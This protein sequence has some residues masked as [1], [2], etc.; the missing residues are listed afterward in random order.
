MLKQRQ[1]LSGYKLLL[2]LV[3]GGQ[4][5][6]D[7]AMSENNEFDGHPKRPSE[8]FNNYTKEDFFNRC[9]ALLNENSQGYGFN[10][11]QA[12][13]SKKSQANEFTMNHKKNFESEPD[14]VTYDAEVAKALGLSK[15]DMAKSMNQFRSKSDKT[16]SQV[17]ASITIEEIPSLSTDENSDKDRAAISLM[18]MSLTSGVVNDDN[19]KYYCTEMRKK[20]LVPFEKETLLALLVCKFFSNDGALS[21]RL[22]NYNPRNGQIEFADSVVRAM[23]K[24]DVLVVEAG[25]GTGK[26]FSYLV[27]PLLAGK[28][29]IVSTKTKALQDQL[30]SKDIPNLLDIM[31]LDDVYGISLKGQSNYICRYLLEGTGVSFSEESAVARC[32]KLSEA[33]LKEIRNNLRT[34]NFGEINF[35]VPEKLRHAVCC[36][37]LTCHEMSSHCPYVEN[38]N[39]Y[40]KQANE[41]LS[42]ITKDNDTA[43]ILR[44][45]KKHEGSLPKIDDEQCFAF[46]A[47]QEAK[48]RDIT[49][50]N[51]ALFFAVL[52]SNSDFDSLSS[53]LPWAD[54]L[55]FDEAHTL[56]DVGREFYRQDLSLDMLINLI[57]DIRNIFPNCEDSK[58]LE[59]NLQKLGHI[60]Y[61]LNLTF[62]LMPK[63]RHSVTCFKYLHYEYPSPFQLLGYRLADFRA[64]CALKDDSHFMKLVN[65]ELEKNGETLYGSNTLEADTISKDPELQSTLILGDDDDDNS[66]ASIDNQLDK[67]AQK[68]LKK[69]NSRLQ[70]SFTK[71]I[72]SEYQRLALEHNKTH[73]I[74]LLDCDSYMADLYNE[75]ADVMITASHSYAVDYYFR[76]LML[77]LHFALDAISKVLKRNE[78]L[79]KENGTLLQEHVQDYISFIK[80]F[81]TT[82]RNKN[83]EESFE[84]AGW[85][86]CQGEPDTTALMVVCPID[87]SEKFSQAVKSLTDKGITV[88]FTS[89]TISA[90]K[91]FSKF[92]YE[93]GLNVSD[94]TTKIVESP[95]NYA[96]NACLYL[97]DK[98]PDPNSNHFIQNSLEMIKE[99]I[100]KATGGILLLCTSVCNM[101]LAKKELENNFGHKRNIFMQNDDS[102][103]NLI[104]EFKQDGRAILVGTSS[105]WEGMDVPG[106]ALSLVIIDK[107]P[108][109]QVGDPLQR[110]R[111]N[112]VERHDNCNYFNTVQLPE[113]IITL[114]QGAGRLIRNEDDRGVL[115]ILDNRMAGKKNYSNQCINSLPPMTKVST[116][117]Q[118]LKFFKKV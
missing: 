58:E 22:E 2:C 50:I 109:K 4:R 57:K 79:L 53:S 42:K 74:N 88:V 51:H 11:L 118:A 98:F 93:L 104:K 60:A 15:E 94:I 77:D 52:N 16:S 78:E 87:I 103:P 1:K 40:L 23:A 96:K 102:V 83:Q 71:Y 108:F 37:S 24:N 80:D 7:F 55:I 8:S 91:E 59:S 110:A 84:N 64:K 111:K 43:S 72:K 106:N 5:K 65:A 45:L 66:N 101:K 90:D 39:L 81:M 34:A 61:L 117:A 73:G 75:F 41:A 86:E 48:R 67:E 115:V 70:S 56:A 97:S 9:N 3:L 10:D 95:F 114:R 68:L 27:P 18:I 49:V 32:H 47:R 19:Y 33:S 17:E 25:T 113:A 99:L 29:V 69:A 36:D 28:K 44:N 14:P 62:S 89:A 35:K 13:F 107:V 76:A 31:E 12:L 21:K 100:D 26:T 92:C 30:I 116:I 63:G 82:D 85:V 105:F 38:R 112:K 46:A 20:N 54:V 6:G